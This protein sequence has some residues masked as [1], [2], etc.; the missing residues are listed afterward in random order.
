MNCRRQHPRWP[1]PANIDEWRF[2]AA[3]GDEQ[4]RPDV[5]SDA[6][7]AP[8]LDGLAGEARRDR[9]ELIA[10][11]LNR[12]FTVEQISASLTPMMLP[13]NRAMGDDGGYVST[14][15]MSQE[16]GIELAL[17]EQLMRAA[18][19]PRIDDPDAAMVPRADAEAAARAQ[20]LVDIG[21][22]PAEAVAVVK[23]LSEGLG[24]VAAMMREPAFRLV[25][26]PGASEVEFAEAAEAAARASV[27]FAGPFVEGLLLAQYRALLTDPWVFGSAG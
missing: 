16:T 6:D 8:L 10:W 7:I 15:E 23:V 13:A 25:V 5:T 4:P 1:R 24:R 9:A 14:R 11:L 20:F 3:A 21:L 22:D 26:K 18:G 19:L 12:G 27:P 17:L 2:V